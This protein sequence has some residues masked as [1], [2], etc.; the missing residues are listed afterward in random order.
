MTR[1][2]FLLFFTLNFF[3][4]G[5]VYRAES[6]YGTGKIELK[7]DGS[8]VFESKAPAVL[9]ADID[10]SDTFYQTVTLTWTKLITGDLEFKN[11]WGTQVLRQYDDGDV[12]E[13]PLHPF[14]YM[15]K[16][17]TKTELH[18]SDQLAGLNYRSKLPANLK[19]ESW[20]HFSENKKYRISSGF[21]GQQTTWES[22]NWDIDAK[23][24]PRLYPSGKKSSYPFEVVEKG[25]RLLVQHRS[26]VYPVYELV[27]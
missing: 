10:N 19:Q 14:R 5:E 15:R 26:T 17:G 22:G 1:L 23:G 13:A 7:D 9:A 2:F 20:L 12:I 8:G 4:A 6:P 24:A 21:V 11:H 27:R 3:A 18:G 25:T 16:E